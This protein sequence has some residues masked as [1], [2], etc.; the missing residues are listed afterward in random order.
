M[1]YFAVKF[2][3][4]FFN[5]LLIGSWLTDPSHSV[6]LFIGC[7]DFLISLSVVRKPWAYFASIIGHFTLVSASSPSHSTTESGKSYGGGRAHILVGAPIPNGVRYNWTFHWG[8][9][10]VVGSTIFLVKILALEGG[11]DDKLSPQSLQLVS[12]L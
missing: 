7:L 10:L 1:N 4:V 8:Y 12:Y 5:V 11:P 6:P 9:S 3:H 2:W